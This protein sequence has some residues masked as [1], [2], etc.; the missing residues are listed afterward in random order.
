[1]GISVSFWLN[2]VSI[3]NQNNKERIKVL[4]SLYEESKEIKNYCVERK[5]NW[6]NDI[7]ILDLFI[8]PTNKKF[9]FKPVENLTKSKSRVQFNLIYNRVFTP[10]T[11]RYQAIISSGDLK[12][13]KSEKIKN[14]LS[15]IHITYSS[16]VQTTINYEKKIKESILPIIIAR[17]PEII[18]EKKNNSVTLEEYCNMIFHSLSNDEEI[19]SSLILLEEYQKNKINWLSMYMVLIE[20]LETEIRN[21]LAQ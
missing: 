1:M 3:S 17:H 9:D 18:I 8:N 12:Y 6:Q 13:I 21:V 20:D 16:Y 4:N 11:D 7:T 14:L 5:K 10:P 15:K 19:I 2:Q